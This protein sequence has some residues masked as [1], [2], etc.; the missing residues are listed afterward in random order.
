MPAIN[1]NK[2]FSNITIKVSPQFR[3]SLVKEATERNVTLTTI[4]REQLGINTV[5]QR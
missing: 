4:I 1:A 5:E 3:A 2:K